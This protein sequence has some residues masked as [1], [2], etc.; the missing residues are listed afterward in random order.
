MQSSIIFCERC[1]IKIETHIIRNI[2]WFFW[3]HNWLLIYLSRCFIS[4]PHSIHSFVRR[5]I[6]QNIW[7]C[8]SGIWITC[9]SYKY[10][11]RKKWNF[12]K[13]RIFLSIYSQYIIFCV[14]FSTISIENNCEL[15]I[16]YRSFLFFFYVFSRIWFFFET[17]RSNINFFYFSFFIRNIRS[18]FYSYFFWIFWFFKNFYDL[19]ARMC[20]S[21]CKWNVSTNQKCVSNYTRHY[22]N[23]KFSKSISRSSTWRFC[24]FFD[25]HF[26]KNLVTHLFH[27]LLNFR[28]N[29][30]KICFVK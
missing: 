30:N 24:S 12:R 29:Y 16:M 10:F 28:L 7:L 3:S 5:Y 4:F 21:F 17:I 18:V 23:A 27:L 19:I 22:P 25:D 20:I 2:F 26:F 9:P 11:S 14:K 15:F 6:L 8:F 13:Y 1:R